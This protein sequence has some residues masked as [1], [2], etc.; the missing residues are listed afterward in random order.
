MIAE[1]IS[2]KRVTVSDFK[3]HCTEYLR[4]LEKGD[5]VLEITRH[6][7]VVALVKKPEEEQHEGPRSIADLMGSMRGT[8]IFA[9]GYDPDEPTFASEDWEDHPANQNGA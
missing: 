2:S 3:A 6:G 4:E 8:V 1:E 5:E 7:K 9:D